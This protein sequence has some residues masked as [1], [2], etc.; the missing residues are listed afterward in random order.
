MLNKVI[1]YF[2]DKGM[3]FSEDNILRMIDLNKGCSTKKEL[4]IV[5][6]CC[7]CGCEYS[8][9]YDNL[10]LKK[11]Y[12]LM[13]CSDCVKFA[14]KKDFTSLKD[15]N[16]DM[17]DQIDFKKNSELGIDVN[18]NISSK[19]AL[20]LWW[21]CDNGHSYKKSIAQR[22][23]F[24]T[25]CHTCGLNTRVS[26]VPTNMYNKIINDIPKVEG[27]TYT[28][29]IDVRPDLE[30]EWCDS[31]DIEYKDVTKSSGFKAKWVC[32]YDSTHVWE[33][34]VTNRID[35][36][37]G[38]PHCY[39][40]NQVSQID[41]EFNYYLNKHVGEVVKEFK[42]EGYKLDNYIES[43]NTVV[44]FNG[45]TYHNIDRDLIKYKLLKSKGFNTI[46]IIDREDDEYCDALKSYVSIVK[47]TRYTNND[48]IRCLNDI[49]NLLGINKTITY[50]EFAKDL[51][52]VGQYKTVFNKS[53]TLGSKHP[54]SLDY[55]SSKN[56]MSPYD[57]APS[58]KYPVYW[59]CPDCSYEW[60]QYT[61]HFIVAEVKCKRCEW[62]DNNKDYLKYIDGCA[63]SWFSKFQWNDSK[64][65][66]PMTCIDCGCK[67]S[68]SP[69]QLKNSWHLCD[70]C[71]YKPA[72][73]EGFGGDYSLWYSSKN[74]I[75]YEEFV[76]NPNLKKVRPV[77]HNCPDCSY[78]FEGIYNN[79]KRRKDKCD[80][81][82]SMNQIKTY[83]E[84]VG[85]KVLID[86]DAELI[87]FRGT[88]TDIGYTM[89]CSEGHTCK[90]KPRVAINRLLR[91]DDPC[92]ICYKGYD[93]NKEE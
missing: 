75:S 19:S 14:S 70:F 64:F 58:H 77:I 34:P 17:Y 25:G 41:I 54:E 66:L 32:R 35:K 7:M 38:C 33:A 80:K 84:R 28:H 74:S 5:F 43:I 52:H 69:Y 26:T 18:P 22:V 44:E 87:K 86:D 29:A 68:I 15:F 27:S 57:I 45:M 30:D 79:I 62:V 63:Y 6:N 89:C 59:E 92:T 56:K 21:V 12:N 13:K 46:I 88:E 67:K 2:R 31:N 91:G 47:M 71:R 53:L 51:V 61:T 85:L 3:S 8:Y 23:K 48:K 83:E 78:E 37:S 4:T 10:R 42:F 49:L 72:V 39:S 82:R 40:S 81:C 36:G 16:K 50:D 20:S 93:N 55:W 9:A 65:K 24:G 1:E 73:D 90:I 60:D 76:S 11:E